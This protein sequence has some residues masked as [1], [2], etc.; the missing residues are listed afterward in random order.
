MH[1]LTISQSLAGDLGHV[2]SPPSALGGLTPPTFRVMSGS[3]GCRKSRADCLASRKG[4]RQGEDFPLLPQGVQSS[5]SPLP[6]SSPRGSAPGQ[7]G[8]GAAQPKSP[9]HLGA[10]GGVS[11]RGCGSPR[12]QHPLPPRLGNREHPTARQ[13]LRA[14]GG[15]G[16]PGGAPAPTYL[17]QQRDGV[18]AV[19]QP[20]GEAGRGGRV[21]VLGGLGDELGDGDLVRHPA[22]GGETQAGA[23]GESRRRLPGPPAAR[24]LMNAPRSPPPAARTGAAP[25]PGGGGGGRESGRS[26]RRQRRRSGAR[27]AAL[28]TPSGARGRGLSGT[29]LPL[30]MPA[31]AGR[32]R[33]AGTAGAER[34]GAA[35]A[36]SSDALT[37]GG[38]DTD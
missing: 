10:R 19:V 18:P 15:P 37:G 11:R 7:M 17:L 14:A 33:G 20:R 30:L 35:G 12:P 27:R 2:A 38:E 28:Q 22:E 32:G 21:V 34:L 3:Q 5:L 16:S 29:R 36:A 25:V 13:R 26:R 6:T 23:G 24:R 8:Q 31:A 4:A 1:S 9:I